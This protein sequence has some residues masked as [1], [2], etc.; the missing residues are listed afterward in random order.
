MLWAVSA[1][2]TSSVHQEDVYTLLKLLILREN[3]LPIEC[4]VAG[5]LWSHVA[6][7][8]RCETIC[9]QFDTTAVRVS[10]PV[11]MDYSLE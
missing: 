5:G 11:N 6:Q 8:C 9:E 4:G 10:F 2:R 1:T 7:L 3:P